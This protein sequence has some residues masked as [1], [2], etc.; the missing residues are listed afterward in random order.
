MP[1]AEALASVGWLLAREDVSDAPVQVSLGA[2]VSGN[3]PTV[4]YAR[5]DSAAWQAGVNAGDELLA[6]DGRRISG[7]LNTLLRRYKPG[8]TIELTLF[9]D[10]MLE[11]LHVTL[12]PILADYEIN[13]D[14]ATGSQA[15]LLRSEWLDG[16]DKEEQE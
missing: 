16:A 4:R 9:R 3:P 10:G 7:G 1:V 13:V 14:E 2:A 11:T 5:L 8:D 12:D 15:A 6:I